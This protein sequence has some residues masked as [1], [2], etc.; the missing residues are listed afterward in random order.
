MAVLVVMLS[1][2]SRVH[3]ALRFCIYCLVAKA[4]H[5]GVSAKLKWVR[6]IGTCNYYVWGLWATKI[7]GSSRQKH[8]EVYMWFVFN[9][10]GEGRGDDICARLR[11][12]YEMVQILI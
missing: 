11:C 1:C 6:F 2:Y 3:G 9:V 8:V 5:I 4:T 10:C 12:E 7:S